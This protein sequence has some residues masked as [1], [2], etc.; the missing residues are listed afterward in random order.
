MIARTIWRAARTAV[1]LG[2]SLTLSVFFRQPLL[3][4]A[5]PLLNSL[6]K[7]LRDKHPNTWDWLPF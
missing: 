7:Y 3:V 5:T 1:A 6:G 4:W 2:G